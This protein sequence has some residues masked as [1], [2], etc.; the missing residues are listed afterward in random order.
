MRQVKG[1]AE[2][3]E[4]SGER[5]ESGPVKELPEEKAREGG[6]AGAC[7]PQPVIKIQ[8]AAAAIHSLDF[9]VDAPFALLFT[10]HHCNPD[11]KKIQ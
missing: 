2:G 3:A 7:A 6:I 5:M 4:I 10:R 1:F 9:T 11:R 8:V